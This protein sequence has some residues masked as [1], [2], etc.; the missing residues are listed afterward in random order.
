MTLAGG[1]LHRSATGQSRLEQKCRCNARSLVR[2]NHGQ[3]WDGDSSNY[4]HILARGATHPA[5]AQPRF[6]TPCAANAPLAAVQTAPPLSM[7]GMGDG[8]MAP[9][10]HPNG[11]EPAEAG[12]M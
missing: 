9:A 8:T 10:A 4:L 2:W 7:M 6:G 5:Y 12:M 11:P 1:R 3:P